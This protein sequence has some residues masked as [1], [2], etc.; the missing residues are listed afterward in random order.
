M[1]PSSTGDDEYKNRASLFRVETTKTTE[2]TKQIKFNF[3]IR[4][5]PQS[6]K[7]KGLPYHYKAALPSRF[8][9]QEK[10]PFVWT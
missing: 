6:L 2:N 7:N 5:K 10:K 1:E 3:I 8:I 4:N 9:S